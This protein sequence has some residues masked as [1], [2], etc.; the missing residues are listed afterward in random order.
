MHFLP[1]YLNRYY[2]R[3]MFR[4]LQTQNRYQ[5]FYQFQPWEKSGQ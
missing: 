5:H 4:Y 1:K 2:M 3:P